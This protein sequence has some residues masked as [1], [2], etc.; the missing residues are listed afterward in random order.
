MTLFGQQPS[1]ARPG[2]PEPNDDMKIHPGTLARGQVALVV[3]EPDGGT[4]LASD[5]DRACLRPAP[6]AVRTPNAEMGPA[7]GSRLGYQDPFR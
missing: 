6:R 5:A 1:G 2:G 3:H 7:P 4:A